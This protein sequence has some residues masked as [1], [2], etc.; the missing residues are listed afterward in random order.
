[1]RSAKLFASEVASGCVSNVP[2]Q[3]NFT[4]LGHLLPTHL[5]PW[6]DAEAG[7]ALPFVTRSTDLAD[8][9]DAAPP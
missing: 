3:A 5:M 7:I 6:P 9:G 8:P 2:S 4:A 1:M